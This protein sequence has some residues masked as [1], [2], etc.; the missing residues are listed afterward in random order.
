MS[1][2]GEEIRIKKISDAKIDSHGAQRLASVI[3]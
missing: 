1:T 3:I 2:K